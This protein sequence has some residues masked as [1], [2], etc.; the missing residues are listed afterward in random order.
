MHCSP[1][2][3]YTECITEYDAPLRATICDHPRCWPFTLKIIISSFTKQE[4]TSNQMLKT[5]FYL[6][7]LCVNEVKCPWKSHYKCGNSIIFKYR[8]VDFGRISVSLTRARGKVPGV[9][10]VFFSNVIKLTGIVTSFV[11]TTVAAAS[12]IYM[13][14]VKFYTLVYVP[15]LA[16]GWYKVP[17]PT[18]LWS[19]QCMETNFESICHVRLI[20][21]SCESILSSN[22]NLS[23]YSIKIMNKTDEYYYN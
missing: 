9:T 10:M 2:G 8:S 19:T 18:C 1:S 14:G 11:T 12:A 16:Y 17:N 22:H 13:S 7:A 23:W 20:D 4:N 3:H 6:T 21:S 5:H 15:A